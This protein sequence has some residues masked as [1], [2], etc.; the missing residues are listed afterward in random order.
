MKLFKFSAV[1][2]VKNSLYVIIIILNFDYSVKE[3]EKTDNHFTVKR[4]LHYCMQNRILLTIIVKFGN[5]F[6]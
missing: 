2:I 5:D 4:S 6:I 1:K 3:N